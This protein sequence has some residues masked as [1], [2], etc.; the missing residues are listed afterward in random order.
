M[1]RTRETADTIDNV[2]RSSFERGSRP[3]SRTVPVK[4]VTDPAVRLARGRL[5]TAAYRCSL[6]RRKAPESDVVGL[7]LL[8]AVVTST[9]DGIDAGSLR[10]VQFAFD[11]LISR[12][13]SRSEIEAVFRRFRVKLKA[14]ST[15][16]ADT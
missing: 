8:A 14:G 9:N 11:D 13:F 16:K 15:E 1:S 3:V 4:P 2:R 6:D 7:A 12:G 10:V 5:R